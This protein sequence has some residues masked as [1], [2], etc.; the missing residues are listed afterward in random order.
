MGMYDDDDGGYG[1]DSKLVKD[2]RAQIKELSKENKETKERLSG[3]ETQ[4]RTSTIE[5]VLSARGVSPKIAK[6]IPS[7][8]EVSEQAVASWLD[9]NADIFG[10]QP[11]V[12]EQEPQAPPP[13]ADP[14]RRMAAV[15]QTA[16][17]P[18]SMDDLSQVSNMNGAELWEA[19]GGR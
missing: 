10:V 12:T 18:I 9:E 11:V 17:P 3:Y 6:F 2:L 4:A 1:E 5:S 7:D 16:Q 19:L 13:E 8:I 15:G 14:F